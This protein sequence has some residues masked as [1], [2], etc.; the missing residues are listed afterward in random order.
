MIKINRTKVS[1]WIERVGRDNAVR[2]VADKTGLSFSAAEKILSD[3]YNANVSFLA[4]KA[5]SEL[6]GIQE[7]VLWEVHE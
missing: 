6:T 2:M 4:R 3:N 1:K 7:D 5:I